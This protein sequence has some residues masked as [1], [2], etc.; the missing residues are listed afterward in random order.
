MDTQA[1]KQNTT[2]SIKCWFCQFI[3]GIVIFL[4]Y[5]FFCLSFTFVTSYFIS[6]Y[7]DSFSIPQEQIQYIFL[8]LNGVLILFCALSFLQIHEIS[9]GGITFKKEKENAIKEI[10]ETTKSKLLEI[11]EKINDGVKQVQKETDNKLKKLE[12]ETNKGLNRV[13]N[14]TE[15]KL[16]EID[17]KIEN[18]LEAVKAIAQN[19]NSISERT[20]RCI[21]NSVMLILLQYLTMPFVLKQYPDRQTNTTT[22][23]NE[24]NNIINNMF[25]RILE[26]IHTFFKDDPNYETKYTSIIQDLFH[27]LMA[28]LSKGYMSFQLEIILKRNGSTFPSPLPN[29]PDSTKLF[30]EP[31]IPTKEFLTNYFKKHDIKIKPRAL[32][33]TSQILDDYIQLIKEYGTYQNNPSLWIEKYSGQS[34]Q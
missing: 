7:F 27:G 28:F 2:D 14:E 20:D 18:G 12:E 13:S 31:P 1:Q 17:E 22:T 9:F 23:S 29:D 25:P 24:F 4:V 34:S 15:S 21:L 8:G 10:D 19:A 11:E 32:E 6:N 16:L 3:R 33:E 5:S 30:E 26:L